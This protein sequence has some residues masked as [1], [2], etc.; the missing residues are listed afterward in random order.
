VLGVKFLVLEIGALL[1]YAGVKGLGVKAL[2]TGDNTKTVANTPL[3]TGGT[4]AGSTASAGA[5]PQTSAQA[6][7][8]SVAPGGSL[9]NPPPRPV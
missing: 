4:S 7:A 5:Q 9:F 3:S 2:L 8:A 6:A 1:L